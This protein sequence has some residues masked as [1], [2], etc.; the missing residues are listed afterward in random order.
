M[1][2]LIWLVIFIASNLYAQT[3][4]DGTRV[5][6]ATQIV[7]SVG[8]VWKMGGKRPGAPASDGIPAKQLVYCR[9]TV[10]ALNGLN[11][12]WYAGKLDAGWTLVGS[13]DPCK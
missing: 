3:S 11:N 13:A 9:S 6:P 2:H 1:R 8:A 7:D 4:P 10:Y 12:Q 5:P